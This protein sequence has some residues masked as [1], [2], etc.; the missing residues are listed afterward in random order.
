MVTEFQIDFLKKIISVPSVG[1]TAAEN[2][3]YGKS[4]REVLDLFLSEAGKYG[5]RTGIV[6]NRAGWVEFGTGQKLIG[7]ICHLDVVPVSDGW[8]SDP[9]SLTFLEDETDGEV[10]VA[11]GIVDDKGPACAAFFAMKELLDENRTPKNCRV[12]LILGT[13]EERTC[14]CIQYYAAHSEVP[15]FSITPDSVFPVIFSEKRILQLRVFGENKNGLDAHGGSAVNIVPARAYCVI[16]EKRIEAEGRAAHA[17]KPELGIN[18]IV[19]LAHRMEKE[20]IQLTD[21]PIM[22]FIRD[23]DQT[24]FTG[25]SISDESGS[26][27]CNPGILNT[28]K[29][30]CEL[31]ID[32]RIPASADADTLIKTIENKA[33][34]YGLKT[35]VTLNLAPLLIPKDS[36]EVR[37]LT[38]IWKRH[39]DKFTGFKEEYRKVHTEPKAVGVGTYAR[40]IPNT[41]AFGIQAPWQDDQCHQTNEHAAVND[42]LQ[43]VE[44]IKEFI[45]NFS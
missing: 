39:M 7:I 40:H 4:A 20:G 17:S 25:C 19:S 13:D 12:R 37:K 34:E 42:F 11:R 29:D 8:D 44:I 38:D 45:L 21:Y 5:F 14:S 28:D 16:G 27:T 31:R 26:L 2:A 35:E 22:K 9:F 24:T 32:F 43:W 6:G 41:V 30:F 23:F 33:A 3:P 1:G 18:A 15:D 10:I 36:E